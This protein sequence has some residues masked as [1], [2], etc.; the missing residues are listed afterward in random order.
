PAPGRGVGGT[1]KATLS[2]TW[3]C[4]LSTDMPPRG[5][6]SMI[7]ATLPA[8]KAPVDSSQE[9]VWVPGAE[10]LKRSRYSSVAFTAASELKAG[11][12]SLNHSPPFA[13]NSGIQRQ[14]LAPEPRCPRNAVP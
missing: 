5:A 9:P 11:L 14:T 6:D 7:I 3:L 13:L 1:A 2:A 8:R 12:P 10:Y 4:A